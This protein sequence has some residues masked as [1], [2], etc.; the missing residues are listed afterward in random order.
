MQDGTCANV[1]ALVLLATV[2][3][4]GCSSDPSTPAKEETAVVDVSPEPGQGETAAAPLRRGCASIEPEAAERSMIEAF[5]RSNRPQGYAQE[6]AIE[7]PVYMHVINKGTGLSNGDVPESQIL[8]QIQVLNEAFPS[9]R[10]TFT[11]VDIDRTNNAN[12]YTMRSGSTEERQAKAALR[13]GGKSDLN[14]YTANI[15]GGL[16][17]W[18]TFPSS[19]R[20]NPTADGVVLL[21]S[22]LPGGSAAPYDEGDTGTHEVGHW[23]GLYHT[24]QDG[25]RR[26]G[27]EVADTPAEASAA[28]GC[29]IGRDT[30]GTAGLDPITNFMD[31]T[32]DACMNTFSPGQLTRMQDLSRT[33]R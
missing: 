22:S 33:Y 30:C 15:G 29:P 24:F 17:G 8:E 23:L 16:L 28:F 25:C 12:W 10:F 31:Y 20:R 21:Y 2:T 9:D 14:I 27:D 7:V 18:A 26:G 5:V 6:A 32:E 4:I 11:L 1:V 3:T 13:R 19:Y